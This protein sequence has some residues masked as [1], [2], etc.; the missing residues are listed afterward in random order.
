MP[1]PGSGGD[2]YRRVAVPVV[3]VLLALVSAAPTHAATDA[4][5]GE[6]TT[7]LPESV[8]GGDPG[9]TEAASSGSGAIARLVVGLAIVLAVVYGVYWLLKKV[10]GSRSGVIRAEGSLDIVASLPLGQTRGLH[11][12]KVGDELVLVGVGENG[13]TP[14]RAWSPDEARRLQAT[15][16]TDAPLRGGAG[17]GV[18]DELRRR[19]LRS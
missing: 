1:R 13:V 3:L 7:P 12:V 5:P 19:T 17:T 2:L 18:V 6:D 14:V 15:L 8:T 4:P 16:Q 10:Y 9:V 11:L